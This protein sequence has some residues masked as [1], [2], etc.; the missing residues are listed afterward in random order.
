MAPRHAVAVAAL[1]MLLLF[2]SP[3]LVGASPSVSVTGMRVHKNHNLPC[4]YRLPL[5]IAACLKTL[6][7]DAKSLW[8]QAV[9]SAMPTARASQVLPDDVRAWPTR[10]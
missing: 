10:L 3:D 8:S 1:A 6:V 4:A 9:A 2:C 5:S 7:A